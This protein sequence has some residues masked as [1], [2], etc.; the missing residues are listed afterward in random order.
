M[1]PGFLRF[2]ALNL[3]R[4]SLPLTPLV[5]KLLLEILKTDSLLFSFQSSDDDLLR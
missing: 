2:W 5:P 4:A 3:L 1:P